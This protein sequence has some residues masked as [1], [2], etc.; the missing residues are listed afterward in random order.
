MKSISLKAESRD[1]ET[2]NLNLKRKGGFIPAV[3]YGQSKENKNV[4]V[5]NLEFGK[6]FE[7][8]G[9]NTVV[10]LEINGGAK[11]NVIIYDYQLDSLSGKVIHVD[12]LRVNM[13][14]EIETR[15]P[16]NFIGESPAVKENGGTLVKSL[17]DVAVKCLPGNMPQEFV[18]DL[19]KLVTF[20]DRFTVG[21]LTVPTDVEI[22]DNLETIVALV[23]AP[24]SEEELA[25]LNE[26]VEEDVTKVE[27]VKEKA[28]DAE[29]KE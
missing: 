19:A 18:V 10:A 26:K 6:V 25:E 21:D 11:E 22:L 20:E 9:E 16:L 27:A 13:K 23:S 5:N 3:L 7:Q 24:R 15:I 14:E 17:D 29:N 28:E 2:E 4:W 8:A 1:L 12:L